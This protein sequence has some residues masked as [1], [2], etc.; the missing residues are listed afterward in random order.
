MPASG[1]VQDFAMPELKAQQWA[2]W[3][4]LWS[5]ACHTPSVCPSW[6]A[7]SDMH[8]STETQGQSLVRD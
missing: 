3:G 4:L 2:A 7:D 6:V 8:A 1:F 5:C